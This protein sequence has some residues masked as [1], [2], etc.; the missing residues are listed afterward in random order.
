[1]LYVVYDRVKG[2]EQ[3]LKDIKQMK[4][5]HEHRIDSINQY[6]KDRLHMMDERHDYI[7]DSLNK[8][9]NHHVDSIL[10]MNT[11]ILYK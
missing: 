4:I 1:M 9:F 7:N 11:N 8:E 3:Y 6:Y 2:H 10:T 5:D